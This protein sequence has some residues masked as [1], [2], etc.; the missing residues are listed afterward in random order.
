MNVDSVGSEGVV[1]EE[2]VGSK[3]GDGQKRKATKQELG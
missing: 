2:E 1:K 3:L